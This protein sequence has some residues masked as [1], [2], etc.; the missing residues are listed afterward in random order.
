VQGLVDVRLEQGEDE[1][2]LPDGFTYTESPRFTRGDANGDQEHDLS[3]AI[4]QLAALFQGGP[5]GPCRDAA[6]ANDDGVLDISDPIRL[7]N[8]LFQDSEP[9]RAPF[10]EPGLDPTPDLLGC[11]G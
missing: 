5:E 8:Y 6:D 7:L 4:H 10:P 1:W 2:V 9:L 11:G 3:D